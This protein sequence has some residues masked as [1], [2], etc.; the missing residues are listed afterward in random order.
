MHVLVCFKL[1][2]SLPENIEESTVGMR[3][4]SLLNTDGDKGVSFFSVV[5]DTAHPYSTEIS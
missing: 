2:N 4:I 1:L 3:S 5:T